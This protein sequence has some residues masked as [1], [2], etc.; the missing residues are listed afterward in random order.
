MSGSGFKLVISQPEAALYIH[1]PMF[2]TTVAIHRTR[3]T[4]RR[5]GV[6][7]ECGAAVAGAK[8][9]ADFFLRGLRCG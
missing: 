6:Q 2:A 4:G 9:Y 5:K 1:V 8:R 7:N 3:Y